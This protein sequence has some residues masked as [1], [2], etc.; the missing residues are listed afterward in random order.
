M[1]I[2]KA[3]IFSILLFIVKGVLG[4]T[5]SDQKVSLVGILVLIQFLLITL[6]QELRIESIY[7]L[8]AS[9]N[10][11]IFIYLVTFENRIEKKTKEVK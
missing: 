1:I 10:I 4:R 5:K 7:P 3:I 8:I 9:L 2:S 11:V 6:P